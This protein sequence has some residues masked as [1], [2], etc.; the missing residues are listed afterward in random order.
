MSGVINFEPVC[1][2]HDRTLLDLMRQRYC[3]VN[4]YN[5]DLLELLHSVDAVRVVEVHKAVL[6][7]N[8]LN[9]TSVIHWEFV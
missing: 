7:L 3:I 6:G 2:L 1:K 5:R 4:D 9:P 8:P